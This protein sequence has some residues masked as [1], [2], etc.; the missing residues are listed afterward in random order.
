[1]RKLFISIFM[2]L[3]LGVNNSSAQN[4]IKEGN[5]FKQVS[6]RGTHKRDTLVTRFTYEDVKGNTYPIILNKGT[7]TCYVWKKRD[8]GGVYKFY[9]KPQ[10]SSQ[11][12][13]SYGVAY[14]PKKK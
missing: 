11:I 3:A 2:M 5:T 1:M 9:M 8:K 14:N 10:V 6:T 12:A 7:G 13:D 4:V